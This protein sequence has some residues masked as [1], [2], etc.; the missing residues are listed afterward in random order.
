M[1]GFPKWY[2][3]LIYVG[4]DTDTGELI[5][6]SFS[7]SVGSSALD[8]KVILVGIRMLRELYQI[9]RRLGVEQQLDAQRS[10]TVRLVVQKKGWL[11]D[12]MADY[13]T[14]FDEI[15][16]KGVED[17]VLKYADFKDKWPQDKHELREARKTMALFGSNADGVLDFRGQCTQ[18]NPP[19]L[20]A[21]TSA[22]ARNT[23]P[24][25]YASCCT[26]DG[27]CSSNAFGLRSNPSLIV[28]L[29]LPAFD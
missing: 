23:T 16:K 8:F 18:T 15:N 6:R 17:E 20:T 10:R 14:V 9:A 28:A 11:I 24:S 5:W 19:H 22:S 12:Q 26:G 25:H 29:Q 2:G 7:G 3:Y 1:I 21:A 27:C 4:T 13:F